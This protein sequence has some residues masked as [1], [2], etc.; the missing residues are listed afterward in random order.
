MKKNEECRFSCVENIS[1]SRIDFVGMVSVLNFCVLQPLG[2]SDILDY[3]ITYLYK[4]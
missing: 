4:A 1:R 3:F 2:M